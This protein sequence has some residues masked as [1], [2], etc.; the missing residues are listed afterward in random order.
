MIDSKDRVGQRPLHKCAMR[1]SDD[2]AIILL[3][4]G[5]D[6]S[7]STMYGVSPLHS[8]AM[9]GSSKVWLTLLEAGADM[10]ASPD[11]WGQTPGGRLTQSWG[12]YTTD[13]RVPVPILLL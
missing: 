9:Y 4:A 2:A 7:L 13:P 1:D 12:W 3:T 6:T 10:N 8:A 11:C 5:A